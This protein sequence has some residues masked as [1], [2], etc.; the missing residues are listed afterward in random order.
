MKD[1][2]FITQ[3]LFDKLIELARYM[4]EH[5]LYLLNLVNELTFD[6]PEDRLKKNKYSKTLSLIYYGAQRIKEELVS[7][8]VNQNEIIKCNDA[9]KNIFKNLGDDLIHLP[10]ICEEIVGQNYFVDANG[11]LRKADK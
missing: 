9:F 10:T 3:D 7:T 11:I 2:L 5:S 8:T 1:L 6:E 4:E